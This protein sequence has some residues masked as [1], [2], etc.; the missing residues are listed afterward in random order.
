MLLVS[1]L[2]IGKFGGFFDPE[3]L[4]NA[5]GQS[6]RQFADGPFGVPALILAFCACAFIA[7][8]QFVLIGVAVF[9]FDPLLGAIWAWV[10]TLCSGSLTFWI[11]RYSGQGVLKRFSG[12]RT[13][14]FTA[15]I[16]RNAFA[17][18]AIVRNVPTGPFLIVNMAFGAVRSSFLHYLAGMAVG[19]LPKVL[20]VAFGLQAVQAALGG[21]LW[22]A[23][24]TAIAAIAIFV[25]GRVY[26]RRRKNEQ[27]IAFDGS[28]PV[29][30]G[31]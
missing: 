13:R 1:V 9:A 30:T 25:A 11:G 8:P 23:A 21:N 20:L 6:I 4:G 24:G 29:D 26:I 5:L 14:K 18:S 16:A 17:A 3:A 28:E 22:L 12:A 15:F 31:V 2:V 7:V 10:A 19:I 27:N